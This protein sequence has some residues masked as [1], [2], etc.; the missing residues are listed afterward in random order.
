LGLIFD[1]REAQNAIPD[2]RMFLEAVREGKL[3]HQIER[4][5]SQNFYILGLSPNASRLSVRFWHVSTVEDILNRIG[6]HFAD[7]QIVKNYDTDLEFPGIWHLLK[8]TAVQGKSDNISPHLAG[9]VMRSVLM[10][11]NYPQN[12][13]SAIIGRIRADQNINYLR[14][15]II[16]AC[17]IR[18]YRITNQKLEVTVS[19]DTQSTNT[20]YLLGRLFAVLEK[21]QKDAVPGANTTIKDRYLGA[22]SVTPRSVFPLLLRLAQHHIEK[23]EFGYATEKMIEN[24]IGEITEFPAHFS[25][26]DQGLFMIGY[27]HQRKDFYTKKNDK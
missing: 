9:A 20:A 13:L 12:L 5:A 22:A 26:E 4:D 21:A 23:A 1:P 14:T 6:Q 7:L 24:I 2:I 10:G 27:Y 11:I 16:K 8:E 15:A 17:L 3:P 19:L 25:M 18:K